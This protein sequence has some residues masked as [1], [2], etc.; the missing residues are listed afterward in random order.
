M[1]NKGIDE[2]VLREALEKAKKAGFKRARLYFM[3]GLPKEELEDVRRIAEISEEMSEILPLRLSI[4]P[5]IPKPG[6]PLGKF[7]MEEEGKLRKKKEILERELRKRGI[8]A[9]FESIR[10]SVIQWLLAQGDERMGDVLLYAYK[11]GGSFSAWRK[12]YEKVYG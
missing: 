6:T 11:R 2:E 3:I 12:G 9:T 8:Q 10:G 4:S 7:P 1:I 5:F